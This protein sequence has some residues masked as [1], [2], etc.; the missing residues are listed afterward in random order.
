M[1]P[2]SFCTNVQELFS[3]VA[4]KRTGG[5][6]PF[7]SDN[8]LNIL[9]FWLIVI[10]DVFSQVFYVLF[11]KHLQTVKYTQNLLEFLET[12]YQNVLK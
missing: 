5:T 8:M 6:E 3:E 2:E 10:S 1:F 4:L 11:S 9:N 12:F 7:L